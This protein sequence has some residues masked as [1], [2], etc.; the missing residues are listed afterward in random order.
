MHVVSKADKVLSQLYRVGTEV[1]T[2]DLAPQALHHVNEPPIPA[3]DL[4]GHAFR[5]LAAVEPSRGQKEVHSGVV[6]FIT[7]EVP[8]HIKALH[9]EGVG[10]LFRVDET[11]NEPRDRERALLP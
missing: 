5:Y 11:R 8:A 4:E 10:V 1:D 7:R 9:A 2:D 6:V 3:T